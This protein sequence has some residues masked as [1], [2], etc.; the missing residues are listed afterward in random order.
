[1]KE[2]SVSVSEQII[3]VSHQTFGCSAEHW[4]CYSSD[5]SFRKTRCVVQGYDSGGYSELSSLQYDFS[6]KCE[7]EYR[8][9]LLQYQILTAIQNWFLSLVFVLISFLILR[10]KALFSIDR[11]KYCFRKLNGIFPFTIY[12]HV[13]RKTRHLMKE[14]NLGFP[15]RSFA[16]LTKRLDVLPN[17]T[18][19]YPADTSFRKTRSVVQV[20]DSGGYSQLSSLWYDFGVKMR[21]RIQKKLLFFIAISNPDSHTKRLLVTSVCINFFS[22]TLDE[23]SLHDR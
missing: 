4:R 13:V 10:M 22:I 20:Y 2:F 17:I 1:M 8:F 16:S 15:N 18:R 23:S 5:T 11:V 7:S 3:G 14:F 12:D 19:C 9:S 6:V 21:K